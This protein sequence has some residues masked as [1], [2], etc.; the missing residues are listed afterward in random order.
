MKKLLAVMTTVVAVVA[1]QQGFAADTASVAVSAAVVGTCK[2]NSGGA[3]AFG[4]LDP[5]SGADVGA[6]VT[7]P[8]FWCT[9]SSDYTLADDNGL[10]E[11]GTTHRVKHASSADYIPYTFTY[12]S[13]GTGQGKNTPITMNIAGTIAGADYVDSPVGNYA[14]TVVLSINP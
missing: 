10:N 4:N 3:M 12:T 1:A 11:S 5:A 6:T 14:D 9:K 13:T 2:F 8:E 7:Q